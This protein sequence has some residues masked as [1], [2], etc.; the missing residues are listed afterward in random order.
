MSFIGDGD[1]VRYQNQLSDV[2]GE[3]WF[4]GLWDFCSW[5]DTLTLYSFPWRL[6]AI[7]SNNWNWDKIA[8]KA[9]A[10]FYS[11]VV[12]ITKSSI[13]SSMYFV[14]MHTSTVKFFSN[15]SIFMFC[16]HCETCI[17]MLGWVGEGGLMGRDVFAQFKF[18]NLLTEELSKQNTLKEQTTIW[19]QIRTYRVTNK[20]LYVGCKRGICRRRHVV[21][22]TRLTTAPPAEH[23]SCAHF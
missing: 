12:K 22:R 8:C 20:T 9:L 18:D 21:K 16:H 14:Q 13:F 3:K 17:N 1:S 7:L 5:I 2:E 10:K 15:V 6:P 23:Q 11:Y 19:R 4:L